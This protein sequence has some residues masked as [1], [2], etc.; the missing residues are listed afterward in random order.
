MS[1]TRHLSRRALLGAGA[2]TLAGCASQGSGSAQSPTASPEP[3][4]SPTSAPTA[5]GTQP[6][7]TAEPTEL[8]AGPADPA[9]PGWVTGNSSGEASGDQGLIVSAFRTG[10][11]QDFDRVVVEMTGTGVPGWNAMWVDEAYTQGKGDPIDLAGAYTLVVY[12]TGVT[13]P[14]TAEQQAQAL[15]QGV[16][17]SVP[18]GTGVL[19]VDLGLTFEDQYQVTLG[20][21]SQQYRIFTLADTTR[22]V[23]DVMRPQP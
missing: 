17:T 18:G 2:V 6:A 3:T 10:V 21:D 8:M 22:L 23:I 13:M 12:G 1:A 9:D 19:E 5:P 16:R 15:A 4:R 7:L 14:V 11:H 20:T